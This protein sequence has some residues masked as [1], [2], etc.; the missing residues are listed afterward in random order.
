[1]SNEANTYDHDELLARWLAGELTDAELEELRSRE[2]FEELEAIVEQMRLLSPPAFDEAASWQRLREKLA[3]SKRADEETEHASPPTLFEPDEEMSDPP[4]GLHLWW[5]YAAAAAAVVVLAVVGWLLLR[6][7]KYQ[8]STVVATGP[9]EQ[10]KLTLPD[11]STAVLNASSMLGYSEANWSS[12]R[13]VVLSGEAFFNAK[14]G[15]R[16]TVHTDLGDVVVAGTQFN[17]YA[18]G[19]ELEVKCLEGKVYVINP[20]GSERVLLKAKEQVSVINGRM[21]KRQGLAYYPTWQK[22]ESTFRDAP[23]N[24]VLTDLQAQY[25]LVLVP[26]ADSF[27][28]RRFSGKFVHNDLQKAVRMVCQPLGLQ[29]TVQ[30]DTLRIK[31]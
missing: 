20:T 19:A 27:A 16:L 31:R 8:V 4:E 6:S 13:Y 11:G 9:G 7:D 15:Q 28:D 25:G 21:Q 22:G 23:V 2:D 12:R 10:K 17:V 29:C 5:K 18:R 14:K 24:K 3:A 30:G 26:P 1:M